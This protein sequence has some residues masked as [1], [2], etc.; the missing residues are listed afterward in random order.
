MAGYRFRLVAD[1]DLPGALCAMPD[2]DPDLWHDDMWE[3]LAKAICRKCPQLAPCA[4]WG[5][6]RNA[7]PHGVI[8][9][10][11]A[12]KRAKIRRKRIEGGW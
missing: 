1:P 5:T 4:E 3:H 6:G 12:D 11:N 8:G 10:M 2:T 7:P 9:A